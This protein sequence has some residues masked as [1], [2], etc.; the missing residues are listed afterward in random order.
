MISMSEGAGPGPGDDVVRSLETGQFHG[1]CIDALA[2]ILQGEGQADRQREQRNRQHAAIDGEAY[3]DRGPVAVDQCDVAAQRTEDQHRAS[4]QHLKRAAA[5]HVPD[6]DAER[7]C[8]CGEQ[9]DRNG[10]HHHQHGK[11][12]ERGNDEKGRHGV[13]SQSYLYAVKMASMLRRQARQQK[14]LHCQ[15]CIVSTCS[16]RF[17]GRARTRRSMSGSL[18]ARFANGGRIASGV[19]SVAST[20]TCGSGPPEAARRAVLMRCCR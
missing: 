6:H 20:A 3:S 12:T 17:D 14:S 10:R 1:L 11:S 13:S 9:A 5:D 19:N 7:Q 16:L 2:G 15:N 4:R 8:R 18:G